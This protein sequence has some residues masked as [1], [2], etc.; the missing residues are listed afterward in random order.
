MSA[1][2]LAGKEIV[3]VVE[4]EMLR[5]EL[6][7]NLPHGERLVVTIRRVLRTPEEVAVAKRRIRDLQRSGA[8]KLRGWHP[9]RDELHER[10]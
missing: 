6:P 1:E 10:D 2:D 5:P 9:T 8:I 3:L 7:L 4:G